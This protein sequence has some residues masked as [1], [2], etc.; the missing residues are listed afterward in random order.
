LNSISLQL[1]N[2]FVWEY[3]CKFDLMRDYV[4]LFFCVLTSIGGP[5]SQENV[6]AELPAPLSESS[7]LLVVGD[8]FLSFNDS[9]GKPEVYVFNSAGKLTHTCLIKNTENVDWEAITQDENGNVYIGDFGN[10][11]N[12]RTDLIIYRLRLN[13]LLT[14]KIAT[15][16]IISF[17]Y[18]DQKQ[19]PP[20]KTEWY[21]D[22]E[23]FIARNDSLFIFTKNR[24]NPF[25]GLVKVY[26]LANKK[27]VQTLKLYPSIPLPAT[28]WLEN[29]VTDACLYKNTLFLLTYR[30]V[31]VFDY[32]VGGPKLIDTIE[33]NSVSQKEGVYYSNGALY[34]TDEKTFLGS[35][36]LYKINY[37]L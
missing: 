11:G 7:G 16:Q 21:Y 12:K 8:S 36:K 30:Y 23:A 29:S 24:T 35:A 33:F 22:A 34:L 9:G 6:L 2:A 17:S 31:Y 1:F 37:P 3:L 20:E 14:E 25:D 15:A 32:S 27:G 4:I 26:G 19:F 5:F 13:E 10:N 18:P 28:S